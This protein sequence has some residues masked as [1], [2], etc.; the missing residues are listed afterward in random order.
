MILTWVLRAI[1]A[2]PVLNVILLF[3]SLERSPLFEVVASFILPIQRKIWIDL[4]FL[5]K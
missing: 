4:K 3:V 5:L 2:R 1:P